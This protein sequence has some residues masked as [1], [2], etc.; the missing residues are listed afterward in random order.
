[1]KRWSCFIILLAIFAVT[2]NFDSPMKM[3]DKRLGVGPYRSVKSW[4]GACE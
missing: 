1:M 3:M 4:R 2:R